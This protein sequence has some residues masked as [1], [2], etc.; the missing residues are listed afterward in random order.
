M[1]PDRRTGRRNRL[2]RIRLSGRL[3]FSRKQRIHGRGQFARI[4]RRRCLVS[5]AVL[6]LYVEHGN[7][8]FPRLGVRASRGLGR[9]VARNRARRRLKE[10]FRLHQHALP[11]L[12]MICIIKRGDASVDAYAHSLETLARAGERRLQRLAPASEANPANLRTR[13]ENR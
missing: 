4:L 8:A 3:R 10:A 13:R 6:A 9:A 11:V 5:D 2:R 1:L 7:G 12:D